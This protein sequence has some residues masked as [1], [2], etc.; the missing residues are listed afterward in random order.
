MY[1]SCAGLFNSGECVPTIEALAERLKSFLDDEQINVVKRAFYYAE[2]AHEGQ[3]RQS[4]EP[5]IIHPLAVA[6]LLADLQLDY[7][8]L[9]AAMLHDV[10]EDTGI[11]KD[12]LR[13]QFG[14]AIAD[15]VDGVS[16]L[17][18]MEFKSKAEAQAENFQKMTLAMSKDIRVILVK[19]ADRLHNMRTLGPLR[20]D[21]RRRI[22]LETLDIYAPIANRLGIHTIYVELEDLGLPGHVPHASQIY[23]GSSS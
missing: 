20:P 23:P 4:G 5:Y 16:K 17:T 1:R 12:A 3:Y 11:P 7:Q 6:N 22:A 8:C 13:G 9:A 18:Q 10:I 21:K 14:D 2:Q 19:L 15:L